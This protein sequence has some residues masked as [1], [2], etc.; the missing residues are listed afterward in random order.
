MTR[1]VVALVLLLAGCGIPA[2][3]MPPLAP[4]A[5]TSA[6]VA[7]HLR[8]T[9]PTVSFTSRDPIR[10]TRTVEARRVRYNSHGGPVAIDRDV[11]FAFTMTPL[12]I[13]TL[14]PGLVHANLLGLGLVVR[15]SSS[16]GVQID[17][18]AV[19]LID[20]RGRS[21]GVMHRGIR[22]AARH[23]HKA[24]S[25]VP[26]G[27]ALTDFVFPQEL[28]TYASQLGWY[29]AAL[30]EAMRPGERFTLYL[31]ITRGSERVEYQFVFE[32]ES[33]R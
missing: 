14:E 19:S 18:N 21:M 3:Q 12:D 32:A 30:F 4:V 1:V 8:E 17:W 13:P 24:P 23:E 22:L 33:P 31:P 27:A 25:T 10:I 7:L 26:P 29:G 5:A 6:H 16:T 9:R 15:N 20:S 11:Q 28:V 2:R